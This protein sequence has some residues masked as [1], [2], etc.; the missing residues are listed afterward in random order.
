MTFLP[1]PPPY[2][3]RV[4]DEREAIRRL[5]IDVARVRHM[6]TKEYGL[7]RLETL[8]VEGLRA[9]RLSLAEKAVEAASKGDRIADRALR[10][11]GAELQMALLQKRDLEPGHLQVIAYLQRAS[12]RAPHKRKRGRYSEYDV[13]IRN[14]GICTLIRW[15]CVAYGVPPTR[16]QESRRNQ[17]RRP[18][19]ISLITAAL[20]RNKVHIEEATIQRHIWL[21][22]WEEMIR[23]TPTDAFLAAVQN[24]VTLILRNMA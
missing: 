22:L 23:Q 15:A 19:G 1:A 20:T 14:I 3:L 7:E 8:I 9:G 5:T 24:H 4:E 6:L 12:T 11:V 13:W 10:G 17:R 18:S 16:A 21:G 2:P